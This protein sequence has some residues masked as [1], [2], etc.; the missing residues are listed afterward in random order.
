M[1]LLAGD[2]TLWADGGKVKGAVTRLIR[3]R[4]AVARFSLGT[5]RFLPGDYHIEMAEVNRQPARKI[6][7]G[8]RT[9]FVLTGEEVG[10]LSILF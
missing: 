6:S 10:A 9:F 3:G 4:D 2:V 5:W 8:D 1:S 7:A